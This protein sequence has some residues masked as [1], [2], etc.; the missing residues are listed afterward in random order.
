MDTSFVIRDEDVARIDEAIAE[1]KQRKPS[2]ERSSMLEVLLSARRRAVAVRDRE[3]QNADEGVGEPGDDI[4]L[5]L[6]LTAL[7]QSRPAAKASAKNPAAL[8]AERKNRA[9]RGADE[10]V[11]H[12]SYSPF[13]DLDPRWARALFNAIRSEPLPFPARD[14][15]AK[16][17]QPGSGIINIP[18]EVSIAVAGDWGTG[19][20]SSLAIG[21]LMTKKRPDYTI[22]LGD[23]YYSGAPDEVQKRFIDVWPRGKRGS[24]ALNSNHEMYSGGAGYLGMTLRHPNFEAQGGLSYFLLQ[25]SNWAIF[26]LDTAYYSGGVLYMNGNLDETQLDF[27]Q[28]YGRAALENGQQVIVLSHHDALG[29]DGKPNGLW[30]QVCNALGRQGLCFWYWGHIHGAAIYH[31]QRKTFPTGDLLVKARCVGHG[32]VPYGAIDDKQAG[33]AWAENK[34][35]QGDPAFPNRA[36]NGFVTLELAGANLTEKFWAETDEQRYP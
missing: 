17:D 28:H 26:G 10:L 19:N 12:P 1:V 20:D 29:F 9:V 16:P 14:V 11:G 23:V 5:S 31:D 18:D 2:A 7:D 30:N 24:F 21:A 3:Y 35:F 8:L 6:V 27:L 13:S 32:G 36:L 33:L 25:N 34:L 22:H 15:S 4:A